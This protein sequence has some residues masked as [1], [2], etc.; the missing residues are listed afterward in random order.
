MQEDI[1]SHARRYAV[2]LVDS[3]MILFFFLL[4]E[5]YDCVGGLLCQH[6]LA[7]ALASRIVVFSLCYSAPLGS[8]WSFAVRWV[9]RVLAV[10]VPGL[11][12]RG[13]VTSRSRSPVVVGH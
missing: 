10:L 4:S 7:L 6:A 8:R 3:A 12:S 13:V 9:V 5:S 1:R 11:W 2:R